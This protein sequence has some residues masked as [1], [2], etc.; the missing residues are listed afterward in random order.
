[1]T[2]FDQIQPF[3]FLNS[4]IRGVIVRLRQSYHAI[5]ERHPYPP[6]VQYQLGQALAA[7]P[8]LSSTIK[9]DSSLILQIETDGPLSL[10]VT[11]CRPHFKIRGLAKWHGEVSVNPK[12]AFGHGRLVLTIT[13]PN[14]E[15][16]QGVV[17]FKEGSIAT[18]LET[19]FEQSEQLPTSIMLFAN[20]QTAAGLLL[21]VIPDGNV[22]HPTLNWDEAIHLAKTISAQEL[23]ELPNQTVLK[24]LFHEHDIELFSSE[25]I[26]FQCSCNIEKMENAVRL[27]S[28]EEIDELLHLHKAITV[29]CEF[30]HYR[31]EFNAS[32][33]E[34]IA[35]EKELEQEEKKRH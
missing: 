1:M 18:A 12:E 23:F 8:L 30:C 34:R 3:L 10:V 7:I 9:S 33:M 26:E 6:T 4:N 27:L 14:Q 32:D 2:E 11:Q 29:T 28:Q 17:E 22:E 16:Y 21:Q 20:E 35:K 24:R 19:Y 5:R 31:Y 13:S 15:R 25:K